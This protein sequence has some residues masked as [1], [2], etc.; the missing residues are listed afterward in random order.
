M[1]ILYRKC[2]TVAWREAVERE[3]AR[4]EGVGLAEGEARAAKRP[5]GLAREHL[6]SEFQ[7]ATFR[8]HF[9]LKTAKSPYFPIV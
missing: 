7:T 5:Q 9:P 1:R 6:P 3:C 4:A 8:R 2:A